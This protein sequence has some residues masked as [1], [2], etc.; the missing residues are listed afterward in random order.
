MQLECVEAA[1]LYACIRSQ[2]EIMMDRAPDVAYVRTLI[3]YSYQ[4]FLLFSWNQLFGSTFS[5]IFRMSFFLM[6][7]NR[8]FDTNKDRLR[9]RELGAAA[10]EC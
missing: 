3:I 10:F 1:E 6:D 7:D 9:L 8:S 4:E 2:L 5:H